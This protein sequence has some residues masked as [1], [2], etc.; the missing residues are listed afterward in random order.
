MA[1][2]EKSSA[3]TIKGADLGRAFEELRPAL[4]SLAYRITGSRADAEDV[5]QDAFLRFQISTPDQAIRSIKAY[6]ATI[7][8]RLSLNR[9]RDQRARREAYIGEWL[10]E[11]LPTQE[12]PMTLAEDVS[13]ALLVV[14]QRLSPLERV[15]FILKSAFG[16]SFDEIAPIIERNPVTCRKLYSRGNARI[17]DERPRFPLDRERHRALLR[18]FEAACRSND[19]GTL[20]ELLSEGVVLRGDG[21][22]KALGL[23]KPLEGA[24]A[25]ARFVISL[26]QRMPAD[27]QL[28]EIELN[29]G[30]AIALCSYGRPFVVI[31]I[32]SS[33]DRIHRIFAIANPDKLGPLEASLRFDGEAAHVQTRSPTALN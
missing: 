10:P 9:L 7:T 6:L 4:F 30:P 21:G 20:L 5:V 1:A 8:A 13:F 15:V 32:E 31:M 28:H 27:A 22:G 3:A 19:L 29:G 18:S 12:D 16:F 24:E 23:K 33:K 14:L 17:L 26:T 25:V 2:D 11:P